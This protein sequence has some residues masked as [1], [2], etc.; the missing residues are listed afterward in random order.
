MK[1]T[2]RNTKPYLSLIT[3]LMR[4]NTGKYMNGK[5]GFTMLGQSSSAND[6]MV[7]CCLKR[8]PLNWFD[9][10]VFLLKF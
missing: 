4:K 5:C 6:N 2:M 10:K 8:L 9:S 1:H 7:N 3:L